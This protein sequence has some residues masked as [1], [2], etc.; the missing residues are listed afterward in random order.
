MTKNKMKNKDHVLTS[1]N[2]RKAFK[3]IH[4]PYD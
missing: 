1:A 3:K 4:F 2:A